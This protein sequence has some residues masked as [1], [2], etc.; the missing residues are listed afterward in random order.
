MKKI[1]LV[2]DRQIGGGAETVLNLE[3]NILRETGFDVYIITFDSNDIISE[4]KIV[5]KNNLNDKIVKFFGSLNISKEF[6]KILSDINPNLIHLHLIS[7]FPL[8]VYKSKALK[9]Y[10]VIQTLHGPNLFCASGWGRCLNQHELNR[11][12]KDKRYLSPYVQCF[13]SKC[14][15]LPVT[16][17]YKQLSLR[18]FNDLKENVNVF[19]SP[20]RFIYNIA[21]NFGLDNNKIIYLPIDDKFLSKPIKKK[22]TYPTVI[23]AGSISRQKGAHLLIPILVELK[24]SIKNVK[25]IIAGEGELLQQLKEDTLRYDLSKNI[26]FL[27]FVSSEKMKEFYLSG[28]VFLM[29]SIWNE[30][31]GLV[32][33]ESLAC[34]VP[35]VASNVG[36]IPEWLSHNEYGFLVD[37]NNIKEYASSVLKLLNNCNL[38]TRMGKKGREKVVQKFNSRIFKKNINN[39]ILNLLNE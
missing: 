18:Y 30:Q 19:H 27:G 37:A 13:S 14:C 23:F 21:E 31:F 34:E 11:Q 10:K 12:H 36:G 3:Y 4:K 35:V 33:V 1:V 17:L 9:K 7:S 32:G 26:K 6:D 8:A 15:S 39:L 2:N 38:R 5:I 24:K 16:L 28:D 25:L 20:S 22:K 29:P